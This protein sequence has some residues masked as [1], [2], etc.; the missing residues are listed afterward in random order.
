MHDPGIDSKRFL[1]TTKTGGHANHVTHK[2][3]KSNQLNKPG[4]RSGMPRNNNGGG[5]G[6]VVSPRMALPLGLS[7]VCHPGTIV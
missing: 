4:A 7:T 6:L 5:H 2:T 1:S 3:F